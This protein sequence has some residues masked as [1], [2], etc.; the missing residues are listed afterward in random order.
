MLLL[1]PG[2]RLILRLLSS[3]VIPAVCIYGAAQLAESGFDY[4]V[5]SWALLSAWIAYPLL[6][7]FLRSIITW[8]QEERDIRRLGAVRIP[9]LKGRLPGNLDV[10]PQLGTGDD[11]Y[12]FDWIETLQGKHGII[13]NT[14]LLGHNKIFT[15]DPNHI[16][17]IL[18]TDFN[19]WEKGYQFRE[20]MASVL[21][22]G[23]FNADGDVWKFHRSMTRPFFAR[24]RITDF[25]IFARHADEAVAVIR[26]RQGNP[27]DFQDVLQRFTLDSATEFLLGKCVHSLH[28][29]LPATYGKRE[30]MSLTAEAFGPALN[31]VQERLSFRRRMA[32]MWPLFEVLADKTKK[33]MTMIGEFLSPIIQA[34]LDRKKS[35]EQAKGEGDVE[36]NSSNTYHVLL[37]QLLDVSDDPKLIADE[38]LNIL[39]AGRDTTSTTLPYLVYL[40]ALHPHVLSRLREEVL[41]RVGPSRYPDFEDMREMKYMRAVINETM[42]L[43]PAVPANIRSNIRA[44]TLPSTVPGG[45]PY[46]VPA[47]SEV[48][49]FVM[50]MQRS[51]DIWG[52]DADKFDPS[53]F[54]DERLHKHVLS[55]PFNFV[56]FNAGPRICLGQQFAYNE[57]SFFLVR[58]LQVFDHMELAP[59]AQPA[60][61]KPPASWASA[62]GRKAI[63]KLIPKSA[64]TL[65]VKGGLWMR[66]G[67]AAP[68]A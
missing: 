28:A 55:N 38:V 57:M 41:N 7:N 49:Y 31:R 25:E 43:F 34:A 68:E 66:F 60:E 46:Y 33:D 51:K 53:R 35:H 54:L 26:A 64:L 6:T 67:E 5:P 39:I 11:M 1:T 36:G 65:Y 63:E 32:A 19:V 2:L 30:M 22:S 15:S 59:D 40:L 4:N 45:K 13:F 56:P 44:T 18:A 3:L 50:T 10:V 52:P 8:V 58:F 37:D 24:D 42:R 29:L 48:A 12:L 16:K 47:N 27:I 9:D 23:V 21:G 20:D 61:A 14:K 62:G 17:S